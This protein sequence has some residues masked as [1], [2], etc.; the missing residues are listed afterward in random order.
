MCPIVPRLLSNIKQVITTDL[1]DYCTLIT[2][3]SDEYGEI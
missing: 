1:S 3:L 2:Q